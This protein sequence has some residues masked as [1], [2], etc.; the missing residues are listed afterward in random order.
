[1]KLFLT[2]LIASYLL[3]AC[4]HSYYVVRHAEKANATGGGGAMSSPNNPPLSAQGEQRAQ[5][6]KETLKDSKVEYIF[7]TN[8]IRTMTTAEPLSKLR[9]LTIENY[10]PMPDSA[11][12][13]KL[14]GL[15]KNVVIVGHS[16]TV[17]DIVNGLTGK[18]TVPGDLQD[19]EYSNLFVVTYKGKKV[20]FERRTYGA[21]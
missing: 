5:A 21:Q 18:K 15:K 1:M 10:G 9:G 2:V 12:I 13:Q 11:F 16:N 20:T 6:L 14:K 8:T 3:T 4:S 17:D 19:S 7:S